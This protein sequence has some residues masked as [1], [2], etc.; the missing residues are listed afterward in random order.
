MACNDSV[1]TTAGMSVSIGP[2]PATL[3]QVG[4][5]AV[6]VDEIGEVSD[7]TDIGKIFNTATRTPLSS[8]AVIEQKTSYTRQN[9]TLT[10][11]PSDDDAGQVAAE[12][13]LESDDCYT[14]KFVR[15]NG[16]IIYITAQVSAF[17]VSYAS[18]S[19]EAGSMTLLAQSDPVKVAAP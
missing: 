14:I 15:Q 17:T 8:R 5:D 19:Y 13:A 1:I 4:F 12:A 3:D 2:A 6:A 7:I 10:F 9:P 18:D 11:G 16:A